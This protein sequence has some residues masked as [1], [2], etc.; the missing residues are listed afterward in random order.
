MLL[1]YFDLPVV[2][3]GFVELKPWPECEKEMS[4]HLSDCDQLVIEDVQSAL[5]S[6]NDNPHTETVKR[7]ACC[8]AWHAKKCLVVAAN[9]IESCPANISVQ[10]SQLPSDRKIAEHVYDLCSEYG[11][12]SE[13]CNYELKHSN[14]FNLRSLTTILISLLIITV[15]ALALMKLYLDK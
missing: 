8:S 6:S 4:F 11:E 3:L 13:V 9:S 10:Y 15:C 1:E 2:R 7:A 12:Q 14:W 5:Q